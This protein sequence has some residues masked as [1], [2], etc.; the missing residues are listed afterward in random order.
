MKR[1]LSVELSAASAAHEPA[2]RRLLTDA[3]LPLEGIEVAF[4]RGYVVAHA[5]ADLVGSAGIEIYDQDALLRSLAVAAR[6][7][8]AGLGARLV[9]N[10]ID[11]ARADGLASIFAIT[12]TAADFFA[13]LGFERVGRDV[14]PGS[15]RSSAEFSS[16]CPST[17]AVFRKAL[18]S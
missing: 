1:V 3:A 11:A 6:D 15:V 9:A 18:K 2:I 14:V 4:P 8:K 12:T 16:I 10:R 13:H 17:A 7:R 5:A